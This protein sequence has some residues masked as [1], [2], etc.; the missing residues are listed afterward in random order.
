MADDESLLDVFVNIKPRFD[1]NFDQMVDEAKERMLKKFSEVNNIQAK[2]KVDKSFEQQ[3]NREIEALKKRN[4]VSKSADNDEINRQYRETLDLLARM[5]QRLGEVKQL[6]SE[7]V[8][9]E[10]AKQLQLASNELSKLSLDLRE[11]GRLD[12]KMGLDQTISQMEVLQRQVNEVDRQLSAKRSLVFAK[13]QIVA[14]ER[15]L[16]TEDRIG[17]QLRQ[18]SLQGQSFDTKKQFAEATAEVRRLEFALDDAVRTFDGTAAGLQK[19]AAAFENLNGKTPEAINNIR[20]VSEA[21]ENF[22]GGLQFDNLGTNFG[23]SVGIGARKV[24]EQIQVEN[25]QAGRSFNTLSNNAYQAGQ[26]IEDF[27]V[28]YS[29]NG[30]SGGI[31]GAANNIAF[32]LNDMSRLESVQSAVTKGFIRM[33][34]NVPVER[35]EKIGAKLAQ[36]IPLIA[37]IGSAFAILV[38]PAM[39]DWISSLGQ[40]ELELID[41]EQKIR[42]VQKQ[43]EFDFRLRSENRQLLK[44]LEDAKSLQEVLKQIDTLNSRSQEK[45]DQKS[46]RLQASFKSGELTQ[47][48]QVTNAAT[49]TFTESVAEIR[50]EINRLTA[51]SKRPFGNAIDDSNL[52][53]F[54][55]FLPEIEKYQKLSAETEKGIRDLFD[56][57]SKGIEVSDES[58]QRLL[59]NYGKLNDVIADAAKERSKRAD[60]GGGP[61]AI[62]SKF[63][64]LD[65]VVKKSQRFYENLR[66]IAEAS[67]ELD[68][69]FSKQLPEGLQSV[70]DKSNKLDYELKLTRAVI[71]DLV[72]E[73]A[74]VLERLRQDNEEFRKLLDANLALAYKQAGSDPAA[75]Q[76]VDE[77]NSQ[78]T[79]INADERL[80]EVL[81]K[82]KDLREKINKERDKRS[83]FTDFEGIARGLQTNALSEEAG[84]QTLSE[85]RRS[86]EMYKKAEKLL[87]EERNNYLAN[88]PKNLNDASSRADDFRRRFQNIT[89]DVSGIGDTSGK[90][91]PKSRVL[92][93]IEIQ[94]RADAATKE[95]NR[96][97]LKPLEKI[98]S[99]TEKTAEEVKKIKVGATAQ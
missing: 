57:Q 19:I 54:K 33:A 29:L 74:P 97:L 26:A 23:E 11:I 43:S 73:E 4:E 27:G 30:L 12:D 18:Q 84:G 2:V 75:I 81:Q 52:E 61:E 67:A 55:Q 56:A 79:R 45:S 41:I 87:I 3:I 89:G 92:S 38:I 60:Q 82:Q 44:T 22:Y 10:L 85:M 37:G 17:T 40:V 58:I 9:P 20:K 39:I 28:G 47:A 49:D 99:N 88:P 86:L 46:S 51:A 93:P 59:Q 35:A 15:S 7:T 96:E 32:I 90:F 24:R 83:R 16:R 48:I 94:E 76:R 42:D 68:N 80:N 66:Q 65:E 95:F 63:G 34:P 31:R 91:D 69:I 14:E 5:R 77:A 62:G 71:L 1:Q 21:N 50:A 70:V 98:V 53:Q 36:S 72:P 6:S 78:A 13:D 8:D 25:A 64:E